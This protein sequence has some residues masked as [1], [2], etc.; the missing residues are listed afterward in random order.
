[1]TSKSKFTVHVTSEC[2]DNAR[3]NNSHWCLIAI[4]VM[5]SIRGATRVVID[6]ETMRFNHC[7]YRYVF[8]TPDHAAHV[9]SDFDRGALLKANIRPWTMELE[10]PISVTPI[11]NRGPQEYKKKPGTHKQKSN[12]ACTPKS[13]RRWH[14]STE[15]FSKPRR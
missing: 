9:A 5:Y 13:A 8:K 10:N 14:G 4:A 12:D 11:Q 15:K 3:R 6:A 2:I 7:G 1:M